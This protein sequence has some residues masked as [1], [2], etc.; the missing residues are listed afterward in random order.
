M[1]FEINHAGCLA[2]IAFFVIHFLPVQSD[3]QVGNVNTVQLF[4]LSVFLLLRKRYRG[5]LGGLG[6]GVVLGLALCFKPNI[7]LSVLFFFWITLVHRRYRKLVQSFSG[8]LLGCALAVLVSALYFGSIECW[9]QW[10]GPLTK[11]AGSDKWHVA[12]GNYGVSRILFEWTGHDVSLA[13]LAG[14]GVLFLLLSWAGKR[15][16][17]G[18][19][20]HSATASEARREFA[21]DAL[22]IGLGCLLM[23]LSARLVWF[24]YYTLTIPLI[25]FFLGKLGRKRAMGGVAVAGL[26]ILLMSGLPLPHFGLDPHLSVALRFNVA[27]M[28]LYGLGVWA[29]TGSVRERG[30]ERP[31]P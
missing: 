28:L 18:A 29:L 26:S 24:H 14:L 3:L 22:S 11:V 16:Q 7:L 2:G 17:E 5:L 25:V 10:L 12:M 31:G 20:P 21:E 6:G 30:T 27:T 4:L 23:L 19:R 9:A 1:F 15:R 13:T 8:L